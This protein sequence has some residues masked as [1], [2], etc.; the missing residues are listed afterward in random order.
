MS[1]CH[2][3]SN[4]NNNSFLP[5]RNTEKP[6]KSTPGLYYYTDKHRKKTFSNQNRNCS[7]HLNSY[8]SSSNLKSDK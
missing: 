1:S 8:K 3:I 6:L 5:Y 2:H 7:S 4:C